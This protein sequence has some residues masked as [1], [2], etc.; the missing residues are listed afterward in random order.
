V[1]WAAL[2]ALIVAV[3]MRMPGTALCNRQYK[4]M[5]DQGMG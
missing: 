4:A 3:T 5:M 1:R 2:L